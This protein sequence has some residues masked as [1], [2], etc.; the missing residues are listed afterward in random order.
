V[1]K[2]TTATVEWSGVPNTWA[3]TGR[4]EE[5]NKLTGPN[6]LLMSGFLDTS[7]DSTT[8]VKFSGLPTKLTSGK[9]DVVVYTLGG[10]ASGRGGAFR[11]TDLDGKELKPYVYVVGAENP[12]TQIRVPAKASTPGDGATYAVGTYVVFSGLNT[13][14][15]HR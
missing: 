10:V 9:Y 1:S 8:Q 13:P 11:V 4:G 7:S 5:N 6:H 3:S 12:T 2:T 15:H 14:Q